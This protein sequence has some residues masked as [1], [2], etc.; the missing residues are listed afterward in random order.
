MSDVFCNHYQAAAYYKECKKGI[1]YSQFGN[2]KEIPC[3]NEK[4][5]GCPLAEYPTPEQRAER[6]RWIADK[7]NSMFGFMSH[8]TDICPHCGKQVK[9]LR[10]V[11]RCVYGD[12]GC[13]MWQGKIPVEW[14]TGKK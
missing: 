13:R 7:L 2:A 11:G 12:C 3:W 4:I 14:K 5:G 10:Q 9:S 6:E 8:A 1:S